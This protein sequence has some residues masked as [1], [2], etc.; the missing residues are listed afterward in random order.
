M[1]SEGIWYKPRVGQVWMCP[2]VGADGGRVSGWN[3]GNQNPDRSEGHWGRAG[4]PLARRCLQAP[5]SA[6][7]YKYRGQRPSHFSIRL[8]E[9]PRVCILQAACAAKAEVVR[10]GVDLSL[11]TSAGNVAGAVLVS[12]EVR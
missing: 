12:T 7:P 2:R 5:T 4:E 6:R 3:R 8:V 10:A 9:N 1:H 11:A